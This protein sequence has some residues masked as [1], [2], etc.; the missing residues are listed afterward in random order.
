[1]NDRTPSKSVERDAK[2]SKALRK[3]V[4]KFLLKDLQR[5]AITGEASPFKRAGGA[6]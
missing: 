4:R 5:R 1:M 3:A 2:A 6:A